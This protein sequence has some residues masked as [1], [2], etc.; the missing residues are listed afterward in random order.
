MTQ[1]TLTEGTRTY[2]LRVIARALNNPQVVVSS[3]GQTDK[4]YDEF[5]DIL[6]AKLSNALREIADAANEKNRRLI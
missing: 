6:L 3:P 2:L 4:E 5:C 1:F